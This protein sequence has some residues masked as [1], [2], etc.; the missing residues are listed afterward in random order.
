ML[1]G[2][3]FVQFMGRKLA[4]CCKRRFKERHSSKCS[5]MCLRNLVLQGMHKNS[6]FVGTHLDREIILQG[7]IQDI[8]KYFYVAVM[9]N[10]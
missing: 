2:W 3:D 6:D 7:Y 9:I 1:E 4:L 8:S 5:N 10:L